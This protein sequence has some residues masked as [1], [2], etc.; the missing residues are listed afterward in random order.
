MFT[1]IK[2]YDFLIRKKKSVSKD[3]DQIIAS[4][5]KVNACIFV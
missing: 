1:S 4:Q 5:T 3:T 2:K